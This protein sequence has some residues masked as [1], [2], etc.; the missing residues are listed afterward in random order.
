[1]RSSTKRTKVIH[2][3]IFK[4]DY[5][6]WQTRKVVVRGHDFII[7]SKPGLLSWNDLDVAATLLAENIEIRD[8]DTVLDLNCGDGLVGTVVA[9]LMEKGHI[10]LADPNV[11]AVDAACRTIEANRLAHVQVYLSN[12]TSHFKP[13]S[14]V[15]LVA[16]RLPK[17]KL[18][19]LQ[20]IWDAF[21]VLKTGGRLYLAGANQEGIKTYCRH[22]REL[23]GY[24]N[25]VA[26]RKG[27]QVGLAVKQGDTGTIPQIFKDDLLNHEKF[28]EFTV[29]VRNE[30]FQVCSRP[31]VFSWNQL[32][33]GTLALLETIE[34]K[35]DD[36]ILDLGCG[37][38]VIGSVAASL[39]PRGM[40]Y[41]VDA[42]I[43]A[44]ESSKRTVSMNGL[45]NCQVLLSD[46]ASAV[47]HLPFDVVV[48]NPPFHLGKAATYNIALQFIQ[49]AYTVL[50]PGGYLYLV[51]NHFI[52]YEKSI[53]QNFGN[54][55]KVYEDTHFKVL[56]A[57][58]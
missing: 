55:K 10:L 21:N 51:A 56:Q 7:Q 23:F 49:D 20:L 34:I 28:H 53:Q 42:D 32:D 18:P 4:G 58:K 45:T 14:L 48:T 22:A 16:I 1:M 26:Y 47:K 37:C 35:P 2:T 3:D 24:M 15:D 17:G 44:V 39:A 31:S 46:C 11:I 27:Y 5:Y 50:K 12:G 36:R 38:G 13:K 6:A 52:P 33:A 43:D 19:S 9:S 41:L 54:I 40:V 30:S 8:A 29:Q 25:T 57:R